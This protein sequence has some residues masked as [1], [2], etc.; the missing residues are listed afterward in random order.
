MR[1]FRQI[2]DPVITMVT[3]AK[4]S[5]AKILDN[6]KDDFQPPASWQKDNTNSDDASLLK[7][8]DDFDG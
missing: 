4:S 7:N 5:Y 3:S 8:K 1:H 2:P 6:L